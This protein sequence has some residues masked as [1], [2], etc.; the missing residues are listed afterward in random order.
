MPELNW[1]YDPRVHNYRQGGR[2][3]AFTVIREAAW[4]MAE[5]TGNAVQAVAQQLIDGQLQ[6][7]HWQEF[8]RLAI[9]NEHL[10]QY[11]AGRGGK[12]QMTW[13]DYGIVGALLKEQY[14]F[15]D[16]FAA[17]VAAGKL[18]PAQILGRAR[19]YML[20]AQQSFWRGRSEALG[21]PRLPTY[22]GAGDTEC[23]VNCRCEWDFQEE[24]APGGMLLGWNATWV[25][26]PQATEV[27]CEDCPG[28]AAIWHP[29]W[30]PAGMT[31][32]EAHAWYS[33]AR[34]RV[35]L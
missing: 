28:L 14:Q 17:E 2:F 24:R 23:L 25:L 11:M 13:R 12:A 21:M 31:A 26:D 18:T 1:T 27:H 7:M 3:V 15:L 34:A 4:Q 20:N 16:G 8:M 19:M 10:A 9:K 29:L 33:S 35:G 30:V 22:P 32:A 6:V 5:A